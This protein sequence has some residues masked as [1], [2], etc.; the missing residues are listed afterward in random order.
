MRQDPL[1][2]LDREGVWCIGPNRAVGIDKRRSVQS[3]AFVQ[4]TTHP[5]GEDRAAILPPVC[6]NSSLEGPNFANCAGVPK[7]E[8]GRPNGNAASS[9]VEGVNTIVEELTIWVKTAAL[10]TIGAGSAVGPIFTSMALRDR[11]A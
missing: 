11:R 6:L 4:G 2:R 8:P 10:V 1:C 5:G 3:S 9:G 7:S